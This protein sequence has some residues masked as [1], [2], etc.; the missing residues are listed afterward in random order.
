MSYAR[1]IR[2]QILVFNESDFAL[3]AKS[4][5][6]GHRRIL[7]WYLL[8]NATFS[9]IVFSRSDAVLVLLNG[10]AVSYLGLG[11]HS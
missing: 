5:G 6:F 1:L 11:V 2:S 3:S 9:S 10:A 7:F 8:P 4:L